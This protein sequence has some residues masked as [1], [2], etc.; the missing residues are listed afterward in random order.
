MAL[1]PYTES[2]KILATLD[3]SDKG[4]F[5]ESERIQYILEDADSPI[6]RKYQEK[7]YKSII[8]K[9]HIDFGD[10]PKSNGNIRNYVGY[11]SMCET[12]D[13][14]QK[15]AEEDKAPMVLTYVN[16]VKTAI[17]NITDLSSTYERGFTTKTEY[18]AMEYDTYV[19]FC[20]EA[21]TALIYSFVEIVKS[22][23][24]QTA[25]M[26]IVNTK[27]RADE[28][29]FEQLKKY[30]KVQSDLGID[31]RKM[32]E[33]M[34]DKG[35]NNFGGVEMIG[36][37]ALIAVAMA[38]VPV[39]REVIYQIYNFRGK[40]SSHLEVQANF[41]ELNKTCIEANQTLDAAKK[42]KIIKKQKKLA[43]M[44]RKLSNDIRVK[45]AKSISDS[46]KEIKDDNKKLSVDD[47]KDEV[48]N[49]PFE[50]I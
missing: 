25:D 30:N 14:I 21:T 6:T 2:K 40:L 13:A 34:C 46:Q 9:A 20:V 31:Y 1:N 15:L 39:T 48:S 35:K 22:P 24:K 29:Y 36:L 47:I 10:I 12:L 8:N 17:K 4:Y 26:K 28:F 23:E 44:L 45:S 19:Y 32:L 41:L 42:D 5:A 43:D 50:I 16:I 37:S 18:V 3:E 38:I 27:L 11:N 33:S 7:L 49:S